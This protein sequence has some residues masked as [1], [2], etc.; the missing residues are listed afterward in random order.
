MAGEDRNYFSSTFL[1]TFAIP[2]YCAIMR[3]INEKIVAHCCALLFEVYH[4]R[5]AQLQKL[6]ES[7][8]VVLNCF[9]SSPEKRLKAS[10]IQKDTRLPRRTIQY[11]LK[12]LTKKAFT[13]TWPASSSSRKSKASSKPSLRCKIS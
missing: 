7:A 2:S 10:D 6:S 3:N 5:Y 8:L 1:F 9:K 13:S 4:N 11:A 12:A